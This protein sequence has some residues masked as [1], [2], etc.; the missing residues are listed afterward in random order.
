MLPWQIPNLSINFL[1]KAAG[2]STFVDGPA[3]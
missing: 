3:S 2:E 1:P